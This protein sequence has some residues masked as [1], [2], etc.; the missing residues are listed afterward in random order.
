MTFGF[1]TVAVPV[2]AICGFAIWLTVAAAAENIKFARC[3]EQVIS[4]VAV[5]QE[6]AGKDPTF[7]Q[8]P[9]E[10]IIDDLVRRGQLAGAPK[11]PW[12]GAIRAVVQSPSLMRLETD[13]PSYSCQR[14]AV[15]ARMQPISKCKMWKRKI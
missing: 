9:H 6:D 4:I 11:N 8:A 15:C 10:D 14:L 5:A 7:G 13:L 12:G 3:T 2:L 1:M